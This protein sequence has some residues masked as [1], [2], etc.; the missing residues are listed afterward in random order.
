MAARGAL[1]RLKFSPV[2]QTFRARA[3]FG[4]PN[5]L[6]SELTPKRVLLSISRTVSDG[7][8]PRLKRPARFLR[9][10]RFDRERIIVRKFAQE[11]KA[12]R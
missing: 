12:A 3:R 6:F 8:Q 9:A 10:N 5:E 11:L 1:E 7:A 2:A 4:K